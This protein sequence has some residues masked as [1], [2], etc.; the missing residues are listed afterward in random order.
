MGIILGDNV[1]DKQFEELIKHVAAELRAPAALRPD[2]DARVMARVRQ[3]RPRGMSRVLQWVVAP[4]PVAISPLTGLAAACVLIVGFWFALTQGG[5]SGRMA[6][7]ASVG[8]VAH[9][10]SAAE[11][12]V[13]RF[14]LVAPG[15]ND[16]ALVGDFNGWDVDSTPLRP[17]GAADVWSVEVPLVRGAHEYA[18]VIDGR[19]WR[20][21]PA[22]P[23]AAS[24][25][26][27]PPNSVVIVG[28]R[29]S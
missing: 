17:V 3:A 22:A 21:D 29:A 26:F 6:A 25:D 9:A 2:F 28:A 10:E 14:V 24:N 19:E 15:A 27:G 23:R 11:V 18:F 8:R 12:E 16:V 7:P 4:R 13:V 20:P 1:S 5:H